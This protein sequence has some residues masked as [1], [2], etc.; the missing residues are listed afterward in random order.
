MDIQAQLEQIR[1]ESREDFRFTTIALDSVTAALSNVVK[2]MNQVKGRMARQEERF[3]LMLDVVQ[4]AI[5]DVKRDEL[6]EVKA[7]LTA[8]E[9]KIDSAA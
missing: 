6:E 4:R 9:R 3:E 2:D 7:R 1:A 5:D 8:L